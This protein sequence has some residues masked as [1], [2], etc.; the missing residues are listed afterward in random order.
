M[1]GNVK[2]PSPHT[3]TIAA[4]TAI[5]PHPITHPSFPP[6]PSHPIACPRLSPMNNKNH[7]DALPMQDNAKL[8][9]ET[10]TTPA[11]SSPHGKTSPSLFV[12]FH[13]N[14]STK[15]DVKLP[16]TTKKY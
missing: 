4:A 7:H 8:L 3:S 6:S 5:T 1:E 15:G 16:N 2:L 11:Y 9:S 13:F 12:F 10:T 14:S